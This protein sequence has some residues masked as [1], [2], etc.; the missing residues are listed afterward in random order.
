[1]KIEEIKGENPERDFQIIQDF[2]D[3]SQDVTAIAV[4]YQISPTRVYQIVYKNKSLIKIEQDWEKTKRILWLKKQILKRGDSKK[5]SADLQEQLRKEI[6]GDKPM[7]DQSVHINKV[8]YV[9]ED[10][11]DQVQSPGLPTRELESSS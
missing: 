3:E 8:T 2:L 9:W 10:S 6:E 5:D 4:K 11:A 7:V 1:M